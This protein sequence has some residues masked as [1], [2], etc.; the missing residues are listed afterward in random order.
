MGAVS[1]N[2]VQTLTGLLEYRAQQT[3]G[4]TAFIFNHQTVSYRQLW[5]KTNQAASYFR[6][7]GVKAG[8]RVI[9]MFPNGGEFFYSFYGAQLIRAIPVPIAPAAGIERVIAIALLAGAKHVFVSSLT[10]DWLIEKHRERTEHSGLS[11][12]KVNFEARQLWGDFQNR[13]LRMTL[14]SS[15]SHQ[16][17][18]AP[19]KVCP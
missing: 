16:A 7:Q 1:S 6:G 2:E 5:E 12:H 4:A 14:P 19:P 3:P 10:P 13:C 9:L 15:S 11:V 18:Q 17:V 8:D